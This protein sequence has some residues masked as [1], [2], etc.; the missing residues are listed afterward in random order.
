M[1][2]VNPRPAADSLEPVEDLAEQVQDE[3]EEIVLS[4]GSAISTGREREG[5]SN[6][7]GQPLPFRPRWNNTQTNKHLRSHIFTL[8]I[9]TSKD[10]NTSSF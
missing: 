6:P 4:P 7:V 3:D 5:S 1:T 2:V 10:S 8:K 9:L